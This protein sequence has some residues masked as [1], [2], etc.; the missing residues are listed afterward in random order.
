[1][2]DP[3]ICVHGA[4][5]IYKFVDSSFK[6]RFPIP[7]FLA[8]FPRRRTCTRRQNYLMINLGRRCCRFRRVGR[9]VD[10]HRIAGLWIWWNKLIDGNKEYPSGNLCRVCRVVVYPLLASAE[11]S[12][13]S[14]KTKAPEP[15]NWKQT[16]NH[17]KNYEADVSD[18]RLPR[19]ILR[20][21]CR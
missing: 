14:V 12:I 9:G 2:K 21:W 3:S 17:N 5:C 10:S 11:P 18:Q 4:F 7:R 20:G 13:S 6:H 16:A 19:K 1:M 15:E 8:H